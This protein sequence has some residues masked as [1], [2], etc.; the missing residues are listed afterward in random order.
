MLRWFAQREEALTEEEQKN[1]AAWIRGFADQAVILPFMKTLSSRGVRVPSFITQAYYAEYHGDPKLPV[2]IAWKRE[3]TAEAVTEPMTMVY[4]G[5]FVKAFRIY[6][7]ERL[8]YRIL[9][10]G[11]ETP[12]DWHELKPEPYTGDDTISIFTMLNLLSYTKMK[13]DRDNLASLMQDYETVQHLIREDFTL[14]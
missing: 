1:A 6:P 2:S 14:L 10:A 3:E 7:D 9:P 12:A 5:I 11:E 13:G 8:L 4:K